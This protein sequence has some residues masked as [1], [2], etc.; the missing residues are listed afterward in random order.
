MPKKVQTLEK[1]M[2][3]ALKPKSKMTYND[4]PKEFI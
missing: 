1:K 4:V 2:I 3:K